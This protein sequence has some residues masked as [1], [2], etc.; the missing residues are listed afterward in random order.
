V[1]LVGVQHGM[2]DQ[3]DQVVKVVVEVELQALHLIGVAEVEVDQQQMVEMLLD[4]LQEEET[5]DLV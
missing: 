3:L 4:L 1:D 5:E 2:L